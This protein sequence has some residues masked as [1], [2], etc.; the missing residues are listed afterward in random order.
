MRCREKRS[1]GVSIVNEPGV[2][3]SLWEQLFGRSCNLWTFISEPLNLTQVKSFSCLTLVC[4]IQVKSF[5]SSDRPFSGTEWG[6]PDLTL[7]K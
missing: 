3:L 6:A 1:I 7:E 5:S 2:L 4:N